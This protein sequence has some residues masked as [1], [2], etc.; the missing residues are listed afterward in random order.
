MQTE[1]EILELVEQMKAAHWAAVRNSEKYWRIWQD[2]IDSQEKLFDY[3]RAD[4]IALVMSEA[5]RRLLK[6]IKEMD[7]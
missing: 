6:S 3:R 1:E 4:D 2:D 7:N 5:Y